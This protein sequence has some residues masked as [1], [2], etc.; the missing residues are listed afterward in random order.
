M[1][2]LKQRLSKVRFLGVAL[3]LV[4]GSP[5]PATAQVDLV[6]LLDRL[7]LYPDGDHVLTYSM[8]VA[9][10]WQPLTAETMGRLFLPGVFNLRGFTKTVD[11]VELR[12]LTERGR[13]TSHVSRESAP[14]RHC[15]VSA[16]PADPR[17]VR[18]A[19]EDEL[20]LSS[21][22]MKSA[23]VYPWFDTAE[24]RQ[25]VSRISF[26]RRYEQLVNAGMRM[27]TLAW[28]GD[29]VILGYVTPSARFL[30]AAREGAAFDPD[31]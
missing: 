19:L 4:A 6:N 26:E 28:H 1:A 23:R 2:M 7:C 3:A 18:R 30:P 5:T 10:G 9:D 14:Y 21:F 16:D 8:A 25:R 31:Q 29:Q 12:V 17:D 22:R 11:G 27:V 20:K 15:W 13:R 24:G